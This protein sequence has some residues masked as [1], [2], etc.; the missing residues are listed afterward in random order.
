VRCAQASET[1]WISGAYATYDTQYSFTTAR[2]LVGECSTTTIFI[3]YLYV[4]SIFFFFFFVRP[5]I[6]TSFRLSIYHQQMLWFFFS[7]V[8][9][10]LTHLTKLNF[11][12]RQIEICSEFSLLVFAS[13]VSRL[14]VKPLLV[15]RWLLCVRNQIKWHVLRPLALT[16]KFQRSRHSASPSLYV[17]GILG[18]WWWWW[19]W[20]SQTNGFL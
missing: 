14:N 4:I 13:T 7:I 8:L 16:T 3:F 2:G 6:F 12:A 9:S 20:L 19:W 1:N 11:H 10:L 18:W 5:F 17:P 15:P